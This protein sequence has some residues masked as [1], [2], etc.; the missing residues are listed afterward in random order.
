MNTTGTL[1][2]TAVLQQ[3]A[4][5]RWSPSTL[6]CVMLQT[7]KHNNANHKLPLMYS[8]LACYFVVLAIAG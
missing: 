8:K 5:S 6:M 4:D 7:L 2:K 1:M 3:I